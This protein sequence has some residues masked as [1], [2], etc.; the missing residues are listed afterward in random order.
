VVLFARKR[1]RNTLLRG[2]RVEGL[3]S[4]TPV[5]RTNGG[6][7]LVV[8]ASTKG[9]IRLHSKE[10]VAVGGVRG[11]II[12]ALVGRENR[13][14][15]AALL[16]IGLEKLL[17][18]VLLLDRRR[19]RLSIDHRLQAS[20]TVLRKR[21]REE[22]RNREGSGSGRVVE[23]GASEDSVVTRRRTD[24][25][26]GGSSRCEVMLSIRTR[27]RLRLRL[28]LALRKT[29]LEL[30]LTTSALSSSIVLRSLWRGAGLDVLRT[31][32]RHLLLMMRDVVLRVMRGIP[33]LRSHVLV[34]LVLLSRRIHHRATLSV[35]M[36]PDLPNLLGNSGTDGR[37]GCRFIVFDCL[38]LSS[39][40]GQTPNCARP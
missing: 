23:G 5:L 10:N 31:R 17:Q 22:L 34:L 14:L 20:R 16:A 15:T 11:G 3:R 19:A 1:R 35:P 38:V 12:R 33:R 37:H 26:S 40:K 6:S 24:S 39:R 28:G 32:R 13:L 29:I 27:H 21:L 7:G 36:C 8:Q 4:G 25:S 9:R 18:V 30:A 2:R